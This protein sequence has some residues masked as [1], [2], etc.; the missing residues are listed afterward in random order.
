MCKLV[1]NSNKTKWK[2]VTSNG[3][4]CQVPSVCLLIPPPDAE[5]TEA[6]ERLKR[7]YDRCEALW[8]KKQMRM[9]QNMIFATIKVV[10]SWDLS[11][12]MAMGKD[13]RDAIRKALNEDAE[14]LLQQGDPNDPQ[15]RRLQ[16][17]IDEVNQLFDEFE[18]RAAMGNRPELSQRAIGDQLTTLLVRLEESERTLTSRITAPLPRDLD[19]LEQLVVE[20]KNFETQL[21]SLQPDLESAKENVEACPRKTPS[22]QTK[23]DSCITKW[24][25]IWQNSQLY[26]ERLKG[27]EIVLNGLDDAG[28]FVSRLEIQLASCENMPSEPEALRKVHDD[29]VDIQTN[30]QEQQGVIDQLAEEAGTVRQLVVRSRSSVN[31]TIRKHPDVDRLET[32][33][34][35]IVTR[36]S[37]ICTQVVER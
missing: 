5:A 15:L 7:Q 28:K 13:Q 1:N 16:R 9:S 10:K 24:N 34:K 18:R 26:I 12:F 27:A 17:E 8:L 29:L 36:W 25:S 11:Q 20:H 35:T 19:Q 4:E 37:N 21:Q 31:A 2:V 23:L 14:K 32:E 22:M 3:V 33:V 30:I 6:A